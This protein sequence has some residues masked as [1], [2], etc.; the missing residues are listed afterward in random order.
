MPDDFNVS[1]EKSSTIFEQLCVP[2]LKKE[3]NCEFISI[4][5]NQDIHSHKIMDT[6]AGIDALAFKKDE[7]VRGVASRIQYGK[8]WNTF[9][10]RKS[11]ESGVTTEFEK[12][13]KAIEDDNMRSFYTVHAYVNHN[14]IE[15][16][17]ICL[18]KS[19]FQLI[20]DGK[21]T[22]KKTNPDQK[23]QAEFYVVKWSDFEPGDI[24]IFTK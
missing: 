17:A 22:V 13:S 18:T 4:E 3:F 16:M 24:H 21:F 7:G 5:K 14:N 9:T 6:M 1:I 8:V 10:I 2:E 15:A 11:R 23:G 20:R 19:L 12:I